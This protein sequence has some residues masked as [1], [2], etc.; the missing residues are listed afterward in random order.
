MNQELRQRFAALHQPGNPVLLYNIWD[1]GSAKAVAEAGAPALATGSYAISEANGYRDGEEIP[2]NLYL[3]CTRRIVEGVDVPVTADF[4]SG[5]AVDPARLADHAQY[6]AE[7]GVV[8][9][10]FEDGEVGGVG[11]HP[12]ADQAKRIAA[13]VGS[14]LWVNA[15]TDL[16]FRRFLAG[17]DRNDRLLLPETLERAAAYADAGAHSIFVPGPSDRDLIAE[18]CDRSA[19]PVNILM[20][21]GT[22]DW[23]VLAEAGVARVSWGAGPWRK[24]MERLTGEAKALYGAA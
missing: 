15:R 14:A 23:P 7:T 20:L 19:L 18:I 24:A 8:G 21:P 2:L 3:D 17:G 16:F 22:P 1:V 10:N 12:I 4:E 11:L 13:V 9:C 6:L 5:F